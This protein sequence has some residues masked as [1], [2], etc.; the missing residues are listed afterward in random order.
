M[1]SVNITATISNVLEVKELEGYWQ[2]K[3][4]FDLSWKDS[5]LEFQNLKNNDDLNVLADEER[6][7]IWFP[8]IIFGN[9]D[10]VKRMILDMKALLIVRREQEEAGLSS[11]SELIGAE[12]FSGEDNPFFYRRTYSTKFECDFQLQSYPFDT[13]E[14]TMELEVPKNQREEILLRPLELVYTGVPDLPQFSITKVSS[15]RI[16]QTAVFIMTL[17]R[18]LAYHI[19]SIYLPS[20]TIFFI[21]L[22]TMYVHIKHIEATIM[23]H[24]TAMLVMYTLFQA[25]SVSLPKVNRYIEQ[26]IILS[27][28]IHQ[29]D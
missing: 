6:N 9:N 15:A 12:L 21:S 28:L 18:K 14:C 17:K 22:V 23:V 7:S 4:T 26:V 13:Q 8:E 1:F 19:I 2:S 11:W 25:I 29:N 20:S 10:D 16:N 3:V 24:L 27:D 5:R